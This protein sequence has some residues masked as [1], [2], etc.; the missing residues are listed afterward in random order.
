MT[1][2]SC[3]RIAGAGFERCPHCGSSLQIPVN[4]PDVPTPIVRAPTNR[5][6]LAQRAA[7]ILATS[8]VPRRPA[9]EGVAP[10]R[11][12]EPVVLG[13]VPPAPPP[14][15][16]PV[17]YLSPAPP[18]PPAA[19]PAPG[20]YSPGGTRPAWSP[21][22]A[23]Q[24]IAGPDAQRS[25]AD[26]SSPPAGSSDQAN[27]PDATAVQ[28]TTRLPAMSREQ[29]PVNAADD[30]TEEARHRPA[31]PGVDASWPPPPGP[32]TGRRTSES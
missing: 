32:W 11:P 24:R 10:T 15:G 19:A 17:P 2:P 4:R 9:P 20:T 31:R 14:V 16:E 1:C 5:G 25:A 3:G 27:R 7:G 22:D 21:P 30:V 28:S 18:A 12:A 29:P 26:L 8:L 6:E 23:A 13:P